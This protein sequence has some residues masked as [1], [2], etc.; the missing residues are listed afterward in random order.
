MPGVVV[1]VVPRTTFKTH[2]CVE[3]VGLIGLALAKG[4]RY[5]V[6]VWAGREL[7][8]S[9]RPGGLPFLDLYGQVATYR[10]DRFRKVTGWM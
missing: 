7:L 4:R 3:Q 6:G 5:V 9:N 10:A 8:L 2:D 1:E